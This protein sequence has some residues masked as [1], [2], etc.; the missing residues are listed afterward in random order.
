MK[1]PNKFDVHVSF[2]TKKNASVNK[3]ES[4]LFKYL[5]KAIVP[6]SLSLSPRL[7]TFQIRFSLEVFVSNYI[8]KQIRLRYKKK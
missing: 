6:L 4:L 7:F 2:L 3:I 8:L 5:S 1:L